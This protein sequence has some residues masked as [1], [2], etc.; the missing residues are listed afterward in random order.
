MRHYKL[1][2]NGDSHQNHIINYF[3][4]FLQKGFFRSFTFEKKN[5]SFSKNWLHLFQFSLDYV[6]YVTLLWPST[7]FETC[8]FRTSWRQARSFTTSWSSALNYLCDAIDTG[9][10][11]NWIQEN[12]HFCYICSCYSIWLN[13]LIIFFIW[14]YEIPVTSS[15][16]HKN[17][18]IKS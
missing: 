7:S 6:M 3:H 14:N 13:R 9:F 1:V 18:I 2:I 15:S 10:S 11:L 8:L 17:Q 5:N 4:F 16:C 12:G